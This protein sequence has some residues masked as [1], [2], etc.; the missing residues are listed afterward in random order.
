MPICALTYCVCTVTRDYFL[1][2]LLTAHTVN[3][4]F[5]NSKNAGGT[6]VQTPGTHTHP[7]NGPLS[8]IYPGEPIPE[9]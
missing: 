8:G 5:W 4:Y 9:K 1:F 3:G 2:S 6:F 7:F